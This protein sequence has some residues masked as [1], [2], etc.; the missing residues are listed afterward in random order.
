VTTLI[1]TPTQLERN[2]LEA[3]VSPSVNGT[4]ALFE[5]CGFGP[6][7]SAA[8]A[9]QLIARHQPTR[10]I[11]VG[12]AGSLRSELAIGT[13]RSFRQVTCVGIGAGTGANH[14][15]ADEI[16]WKHW[17]SAGLAGAHPQDGIGDVLPLAPSLT[18]AT[19]LGGELLTVCAASSNETD[20]AM[21][22][23]RYPAAAAEDM[24]GFGVAVACYFGGIPLQVIRGI[25][26]RA[27][28]RNK[29]NW[30]IEGALH[31]AGSLTRKVLSA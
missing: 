16:G 25:S 30:D 3:L 1:L 27:G 4:D 24:E 12:I 6:V 15:S 23:A 9:M 28:D 7:A 31:A 18:D 11:L 20:V 14:K 26:N 5:L 29:R 10:V 13:A 21:R 19:E 22:L 8:R 17:I 2:L